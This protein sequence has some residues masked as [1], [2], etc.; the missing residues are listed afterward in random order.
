MAGDNEAIGAG[1]EF[2]RNMSK[3]VND[4]VERIA[5]PEKGSLARRA[6]LGGRRVDASSLPAEA[7]HRII[8]M[9]SARQELHAMREAIGERIRDLDRLMEKEG[10]EMLKLLG[11]ERPDHCVIGIYPFLQ[12][13]DIHSPQDFLSALRDEIKKEKGNG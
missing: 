7:W 1:G 9:Q 4:A 13:I 3:E 2:F 6:A 12:A 8:G 5:D 11:V 10:N